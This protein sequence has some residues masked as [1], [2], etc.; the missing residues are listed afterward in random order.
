MP[1]PDCSTV[2]GNSGQRER[3][4]FALWPDDGVRTRLATAAETV[5]HG[6]RVPT[7]NLHLTLAF[8]GDC[9]ERAREAAVRVAGTVVAPMF[10]LTLTRCGTFRRS[11]VAWLAPEVTPPALQT[12]VTGLH[13]ELTDAGFG[14]D[15]RPFRPH[16]TV[17]RKAAPQRT[18]TI[19]P[20]DWPVSEF[21]LVVSRLHPDGAHYER[22]HR[23]PLAAASG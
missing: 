7:A 9:D 18:R 10:A 22:L 21:C 19:T 1:C 15:R 5:R 12:L 23:W 13:E 3:L 16:V 14:L 6:R 20:I 11:G 4:F 2:P 8:L 17:A